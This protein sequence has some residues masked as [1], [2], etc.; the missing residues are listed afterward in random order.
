MSGDTFV[1]PSD[2]VTRTE[3]ASLV[4]AL[5]TRADSDA[6]A[7]T[8]LDHNA[9]RTGV[10]R[11]LTWRELYLRVG[12]VAAGLQ[13]IAD[14]SDRVAILCPQDLTYPV[15]FLGALAAGM[16]AVPLFAPE[17]ESHVDRLTGAL[18]DCEPRVWLTAE[19]TLD[20]TRRLQ[21]HPQLASDASVLAVDRTDPARGGSFRF[22]DTD[23]DSVAYL[24]YTSGSTRRPA[25]AMITHR[26][27]AANVRQVAEAFGVDGGWTC[28]G[29]LP[30]FHDM[31]LVL[32]VC[33]PAGTG[34]DSVFC[35]P[36]DFV[37]R[38]LAWLSAM[39]GRA[40]V[41][42]AA[43]N[44]AFD[45]AVERTQPEDRRP[46][47]LSGVRV[48][49]NGS[50]PVRP[51]TVQRFQDTFAEHGFAAGALRPCYGLAEATVFVSATDAA[52]PKLASFDRSELAGGKAVSHDDDYGSIELV[53]AGT[54][55]GQLV[56]IVDPATGSLKRDG[57]V[58]EIWIHGP[59][60]ASGY[61]RQPE[62]GAE[63]FGGVLSG[64]EDLPA[65]GWLR[66]GDLGTFAD[67]AL[68][69]T[70]RLK[71]LII[72]DGK[73]HYPHD[74]EDTVQEAHAAIRP[75]RVAVFGIPTD[76][77][78]AVV[79]VLERASGETSHGVEEAEISLAVRRAVGREHDLKLH[80]VQVLQDA[81]VLRTS[82]GKIA[83]SAN[84]ARYLNSLEV[85]A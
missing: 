54:P 38:P 57:E 72:V 82:S 22:P 83:R 17:V 78:E 49:I 4:E 65:S 56:C 28:V 33:L 3:S 37:R 62:R 29:W 84:R 52:G 80:D 2:K 6:P 13:E 63:A 64:G 42:T 58:G 79:V 19:A 10:P 59:N 45:Y 35:T 47:D 1:T 27:V 20:P 40:D 71:D 16:V 30:F 23:P 12:S 21:R 51:R 25:G 75:G 61:W 60:V 32:L 8:Y 43:P 34:A 26:A 50:E 74:I 7:F 48:A 15:A 70:G 5:A 11:T 85:R 44:F 31:G 67:G 39:S 18:A 36:F 76:S 24:Q 69:V 77:G 46:L 41:I 9:S 73:N 53:G 68:F 66:T 55:V 81:K 14:P